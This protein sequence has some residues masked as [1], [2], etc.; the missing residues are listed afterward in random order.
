[1]GDAARAAGDA[2]RILK[3]GKQDENRIIASSLSYAYPEAQD[4]A[5]SDVSM[6]VKLSL[7]H[8]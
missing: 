1:M 2:E 4:N 6:R 5:V 7:I 8:I 3:L